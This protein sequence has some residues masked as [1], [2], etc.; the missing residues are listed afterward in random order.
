MRI[1]LRCFTFERRF[2]RGAVASLFNNAW[3]RRLLSPA[4]AINPL[5]VGALHYDDSPDLLQPNVYRINPLHSIL[6]SP[7]S[8]FGSGYSR[9]IKPDVL[10][11][12]GRQTYKLPMVVKSPQRIEI[13]AAYRRN[14]G[15]KFAT[16]STVA[17]ELNATVYG[18]GTKQCYSAHVTQ[19]RY[20]L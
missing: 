18:C 8:A 2:G 16:P 7:V 20:L 1:Y 14:P 9:S 5:T 17:G 19:C 13:G 11:S 3:N 6:P 10:C 4:E 15:N 12:G